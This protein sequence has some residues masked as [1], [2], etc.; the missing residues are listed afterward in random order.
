MSGR[1][2]QDPTAVSH[3]YIRGREIPL[4]SRQKELLERYKTVPPA[5]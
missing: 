4:T 2:T 3:V 1:M 5:Y